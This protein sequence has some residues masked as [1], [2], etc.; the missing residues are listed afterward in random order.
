MNEI[1]DSLRALL[2]ELFPGLDFS[3]LGASTL[4]EDTGLDSLDRATLLL[5]VQDRFGIRIPDEAVEDMDT[6]GK[7]GNFIARERKGS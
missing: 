2:G 3:G 5:A 6:L 4:F 1:E 7:V